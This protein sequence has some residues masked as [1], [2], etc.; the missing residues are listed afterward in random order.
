MHA[1]GS[2]FCGAVRYEIDG[3]IGPAYYCHCS[4]CRK[5]SGSA[6]TANAV[7]DPAHFHV[8]AGKDRLR[9]Q[10]SED[11]I[12]RWF[13]GDCGSPIHVS[14]GEHM[15]LRLGSL[16]SNLADRPKFHIFVGSKADWYD[17]HDDLPRHDE[18]P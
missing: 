10:T 1:T 4:R 18:R 15:R 16:D 12:S 13:C 14:Q 2:C 6:F 3:E 8:V 11:G 17:I 5:I 9:A 7:V